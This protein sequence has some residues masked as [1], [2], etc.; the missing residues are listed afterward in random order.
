[1]NK[2]HSR[3]QARIWKL[4]RLCGAGPVPDGEKGEFLALLGGNGT[5]RTTS[6]KPLSEAA[7]TK[8]PKTPRW[9]QTFPSLG[10]KESG[11][12]TSLL[13]MAEKMVYYSYILF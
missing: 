7:W 10:G 11:F 6:L 13:Q 5:G 3:T 1:M 2:L 4:L 9:R 8:T 12:F